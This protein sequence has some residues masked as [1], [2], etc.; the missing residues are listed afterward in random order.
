MYKNILQSI[1]HVAIWPIISFAIF[2][3]FFICLLWW[4]LTADKNYITQMKQL[5]LEDGEN[6]TNL[7]L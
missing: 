6:E 1:E 4:V 2:F 7:K 3:I 5:P